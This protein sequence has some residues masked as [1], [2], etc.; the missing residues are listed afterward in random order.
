MTNAINTKLLIQDLTW[1]ADNLDAVQKA[2][3][4]ADFDPLV[5]AVDDLHG[6]LIESRRKRQMAAMQ[7]DVLAYQQA[8]AEGRLSQFFADMQPEQR[9]AFHAYM[10]DLAARLNLPIPAYL[11][12]LTG[13]GRTENMRAALQGPRADPTPD[14]ARRTLRG[15]LDRLAPEE[16][17]E[18]DPHGP[19]GHP[20][21]DNGPD[22]ATL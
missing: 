1:L 13:D 7:A 11:E 12:P 15:F 18:L 10:A 2:M 5:Q 9:A 20:T 19:Y 4:A 14:Q 8:Q 17:A 21:T 22:D 16:R 6:R 3:P